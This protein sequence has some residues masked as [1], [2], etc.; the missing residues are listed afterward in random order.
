MRGKRPRVAIFFGGQGE[1]NDLSEETGY[2]MC[3]YV[4][5]AKYDVA[6]VRVLND[7]R[8]QVPMGGLPRYGRVDQMMHHLFGALPVVSPQ[9]GLARLTNDRVDSL[10]TV[11]RGAGGDDGA[12]HGLG[13]IL[14]VPVVGSPLP[15]YHQTSDKYLTG[16]ALTGLAEVPPTV[17][18]RSDEDPESIVDSIRES[19][20]PPVFVKPVRE[21]GSVGIEEVNNLDE[22]QAAIKRA[23]KR[24]DLIIQKKAL[25]E[26]LNLTLMEDGRG[27]L[28]TLPTT[29]IRPVSASYYDSFA[30]RRAGRVAFENQ[31][32]EQSAAVKQAEEIARESYKKLGCRETA[33]FDMVLEGEKAQLLEVNLIPTLSRFTPWGQQLA[34]GRYNPTEVLDWMIRRSL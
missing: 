30:K 5:R 17:R 31:S 27:N 1:N 11:M 13:K 26:E 28:V 25:G 33:S 18:Y 7:G 22:L 29:K 9:E 3:Q 10:M 19:F 16:Q 24:G 8:W 14:A 20:F 4:S 32:D 15:A 34:N 21:E 6:P 2:W 12:L 23:Q